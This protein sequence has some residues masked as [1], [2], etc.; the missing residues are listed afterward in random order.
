MQ[1]AHLCTEC[2][3]PMV[4][5]RHEGKYTDNGEE[6]DRFAIYKCDQCEIEMRFDIQNNKWVKM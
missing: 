1:V 2:S 3:T 5:M 6:K 4:L